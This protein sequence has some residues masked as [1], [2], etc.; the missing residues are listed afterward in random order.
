MKTKL[1]EYIRIQKLLKN[2]Q[3]YKRGQNK[4]EI[5]LEQE[6]YRFQDFLLRPENFKRLSFEYFIAIVAMVDIYVNIF[7]L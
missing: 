7:S 4:D 2:A 5:D 3:K 6:E 1:I